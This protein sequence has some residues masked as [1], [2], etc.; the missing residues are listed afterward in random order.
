MPTEFHDFFIGDKRHRGDKAPRRGKG[1]GLIFRRLWPDHWDEIA[2]QLP[3]KGRT[4]GTAAP[5]VPWIMLMMEW[6]KY[7]PAFCQ[8]NTHEPEGVGWDRLSIWKAMWHLL[9]YFG[10]WDGRWGMGRWWMAG[11][12]VWDGRQFL[13]FYLP[14]WKRH[15]AS[16][17]TLIG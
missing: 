14:V 15:L 5:A 2:G 8:K 10:R 11:Q 9:G 4:F 6:W 7:G 16:V 3:V 1:D 12:V 17:A 13:I